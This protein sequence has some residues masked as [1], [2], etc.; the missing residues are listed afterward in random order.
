MNR[1]NVRSS[2]SK[3]C[4]W[5]S[6]AL[7]METRFFHVWCCGFSGILFCTSPERFFLGWKRHWLSL[8]W[9]NMTLPPQCLAKA[10]KI[11]AKPRTLKNFTRI[12]GAAAFTSNIY[13]WPHKPQRIFQ[14]FQAFASTAKTLAVIELCGKTYCR[15]QQQQLRRVETMSWRGEC[16]WEEDF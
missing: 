2:Y 6:S 12:S 10:V 8:W 14:G 5:S 4:W 11:R 3:R 15:A 16:G 13:D 1:E 7:L 9:I